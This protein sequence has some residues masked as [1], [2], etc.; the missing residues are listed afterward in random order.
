MIDGHVHITLEEIEN[1]ALFLRVGLRPHQ[2]VT[3]KELFE[4]ALQTRTALRLGVERTHFEIG[5]F[6]KT[7]ASR[8]NHV[9]SF[10]GV[11]SNTN[12]KSPVIVVFSKFLRCSVN[13]NHLMHSQTD[14][15]NFETPSRRSVGEVLRL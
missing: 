6:Q 15:F 3:K 14:H 2:S 12:L 5:G 4:N 10:T 11:S 1:A 8:D 13:V 7:S 9:I